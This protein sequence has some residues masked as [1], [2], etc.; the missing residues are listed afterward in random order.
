MVK[1]FQGII[2]S[3]DERL[4]NYSKEP[5]IVQSSNLN[6]E[7]GQIQCIFTDKTGTLTINQME[8][9]YLFVNDHEFD[10]KT[11]IDQGNFESII[12]SLLACSI[13]N[14]VLVENGEK[15]SKYTVY[16]FFLKCFLQIYYKCIKI[17]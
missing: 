1:F 6:E 17:Y 11:D 16:S 15:N 12:F 14:S 2:I 10:I 8:F 13:C 5:C 9:K 3:K 4:Q 7:L